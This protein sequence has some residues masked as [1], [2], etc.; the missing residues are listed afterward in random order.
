MGKLTTTGADLAAAHENFTL[1]GLAAGA[2]VAGMIGDFN[3][4][5]AG[6]FTGSLVLECSFDGGTTALPVATID[7]SAFSITAPGAWVVRNTERGVLHRLRF[8]SHTS[9]MAACR[10]SAG[11]AHA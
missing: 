8:T 7:G 4:S 9:G 10:L 1:N 6:T 5:V 11:A 3:V 2:W